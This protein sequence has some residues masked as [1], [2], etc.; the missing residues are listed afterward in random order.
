MASSTASSEDRTVT[1]LCCWLLTAWVMSARVASSIALRH[2]SFGLF[3]P[4]ISDGSVRFV[5]FV[6]RGAFDRR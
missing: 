1:V 4:G 2:R 3:W 6:T 5:K